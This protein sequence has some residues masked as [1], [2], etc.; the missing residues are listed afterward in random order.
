MESNKNEW[1]NEMSEWNSGNYVHFY[2][3]ASGEFSPLLVCLRFKRVS[4]KDSP[5]IG[6]HFIIK[7][8]SPYSDLI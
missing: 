5:S 6:I 1:K 2:D 3:S 4:I 8:T 7:Q